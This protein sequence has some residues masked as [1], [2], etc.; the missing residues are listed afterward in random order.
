[1]HDIKLTTEELQQATRAAA[2]AAAEEAAFTAARLFN[3]RLVW[4]AVLVAVALTLLVS[5]IIAYAVTRLAF[6]SVNAANVRHEQF[7]CRIV[8]TASTALDDFLASDAKDRAG[9]LT[10]ADRAKVLAAFGKILEPRFIRRLADEQHN[11]DQRTIAYWRGTLR[12][13]LD[14]V[15]ATDCTTFT[16]S[17]RHAR[18]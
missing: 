9:Q 15:V 4:R 2:K 11:L 6:H 12:R 8:T 3:R 7:N 5:G 10:T 16:A 14:R 18:R 13:R 1:M 17:S